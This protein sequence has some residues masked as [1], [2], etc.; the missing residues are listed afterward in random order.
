MPDT[1]LV[2]TSLCAWRALWVCYQVSQASGWTVCPCRLPAAL[3]ALPEA[4]PSVPNSSA[5]GFGLR[6]A[7]TGTG[8]VCDTGGTSACCVLGG[9]ASASA[10][11]AGHQHSC[12]GKHCSQ[13]GSYCNELDHDS[14]GSCQTGIKTLPS[15]QQESEQIRLCFCFSSDCL[16]AM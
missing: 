7:V 1:P 6:R 16:T 2:R 12:L 13:R 4:A 5:V 11:Q 14:P 9:T 10:F 3:L 15:L 8:G